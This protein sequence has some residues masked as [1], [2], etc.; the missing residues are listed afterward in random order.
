MINA[1]ST[2]PKLTLGFTNIS[3]GPT[4]SNKELIPKINKAQKIIPAIPEMIVKKIDSKR[5]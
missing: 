1:M 3:T 4:A 5:I 2:T